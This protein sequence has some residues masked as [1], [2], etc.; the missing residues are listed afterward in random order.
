MPDPA[1]DRSPV[2]YRYTFVFSDGSRKE[3][4]V[5]LDPATLDLLADP[6]PAY[7]PWTRLSYHQCPNCPLDETRH[8]RCPIAE[9]MVDLIV[10]FKDLRSFDEVDALVEGRGRRYAKHTSLQKAASSLIG[11]HMATSGCPVLDKLRPMA[12]THLP[13]ATSEET[14]YRTLAMY[15]MAQAFRKQAGR[16]PD[17]DLQGLVGFLQEI[18]KVNAGYCERLRSLQIEDASLNAIIVLNSLGMTTEM[19]IEANMTDRLRGWF[20]AYE[21]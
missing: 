21:V 1:E 18:Q 12:G 11:L 20:R 2:T 14:T 8:P 3:F 16:T 4:T 5:R 19:E 6:R 17:W 15:L 7:P 10:F 9:K 13:F